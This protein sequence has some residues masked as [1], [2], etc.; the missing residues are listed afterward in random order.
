[1]GDPTQLAVIAGEAI[2]RRGGCTGYG[3]S[4]TGGLDCFVTSRFAMTIG[5]LG[6]V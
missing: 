4:R 5:D 3:S 6:P 1:M 2:Q